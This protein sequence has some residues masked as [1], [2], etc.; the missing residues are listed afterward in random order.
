MRLG[1]RTG[2]NTGD[3]VVGNV[4]STRKRNYTV[5]GDAV[6]LASRLEGANK[7]TGTSILLGPQTAAQ[8]G[9]AMVL[10]PVARLQVKGKTQAAEVFE[11]M[12]EPGNCDS[13]TIEF[14]ALFTRGFDAYCK[15]NF[16]AAAEMFAS[17]AVLRSGD[18]LTATYLEESVAF[19]REPPGPDWHAVL[20]LETK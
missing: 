1:M 3:V 11:L 4:G 19:S 15:R 6:N 14:A 5:L 8:V 13:A 9:T 7:Q 10:R 17:A 20:K 18:A 2:I 16:A 12:G